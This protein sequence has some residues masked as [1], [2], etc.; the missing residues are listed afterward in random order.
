MVSWQSAENDPEMFWHVLYI[1][2][3]KFCYVMNMGKASMHDVLSD[4][5]I[6][7]FCIKEIDSVFCLCLKGEV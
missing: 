3:D 4:K 1:P 5:P 7:S 6:F 2:S